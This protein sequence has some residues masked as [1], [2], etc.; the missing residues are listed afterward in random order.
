MRAERWK[1]VEELYEAAMV[2]APEKRGGFLEE[3]CS[4]VQ[5]RGE[6]RSLLDQQTSRF[7]ERFAAVAE[8]A[9]GRAPGQ[10]HRDEAGGAFRTTLAPATTAVE[11]S[12]TVPFSEP[13]AFW[14]C[15][16][17]GRKNRIVAGRP[18]PSDTG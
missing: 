3:A 5:L 6:V 4:H 11:L 8:P 2:L 7:L 16:D 17:R 1:S 14:A 12:V 13:V 18:V 15:A 9:E 10:R